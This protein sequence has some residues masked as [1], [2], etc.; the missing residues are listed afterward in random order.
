[1]GHG[2]RASNAAQRGAKSRWLARGASIQQHKAWAGN[3][4][5]EVMAKLANM[6]LEPTKEAYDQALQ[7]LIREHE[8]GCCND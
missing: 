7:T 2:R 4:P 6:K 3:V 8:E 1:M 5:P